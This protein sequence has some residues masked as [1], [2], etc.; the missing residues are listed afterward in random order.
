MTYG[1]VTSG[2]KQKLLSLQIDSVARFPKTQ[3]V[4]VNQQMAELKMFGENGKKY[5][6]G[7]VTHAETDQMVVVRL[8]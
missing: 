2:I 5:Y 7:S 6:Y 3:R 8:K 4:T 1:N